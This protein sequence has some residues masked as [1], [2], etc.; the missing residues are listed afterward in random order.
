[1]TR[2]PELDI[3]TV[4][5]DGK[6]DLPAANWTLHTKYYTA[7]I[8]FVFVDTHGNKS[9]D[10]DA[11]NAESVCADLMTDCQALMMVHDATTADSL[12]KL[13]PWQAVLDIFDIPMVFCVGNEKQHGHGSSPQHA[14]G[15]KWSESIAAIPVEY[16]EIPHYDDTT[17]T[18]DAKRVIGGSSL[19]D[20][21]TSSGADSLAESLSCHMWPNMA[22]ND[23]SVSRNVA[24]SSSRPDSSDN[25]GSFQSAAAG[26]GGLSSEMDEKLLADMKAR[27]GQKPQGSDVSAADEAAPSVDTGSADVN[28][29]AGANVDADVDADAAAAAAAAKK[30]EKN[31]RKKQRQKQR[32][33]ERQQAERSAQEQASTRTGIQ[34]LEQ[35]LAAIRANSSDTNPFL[36]G[37]PTST[38]AASTNDD[39]EQEMETFAAMFD[40]IRAAREQA[41]N[42]S[43]DERRRI[44]EK[45]IMKLLATYG[46]MD[47]ESDPDPDPD[48]VAQDSES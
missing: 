30:R 47:D 13:V 28:V 16:V 40:S 11:S 29:D 41:P 35:K 23:P 3:V 48:T 6:H 45:N 2:T 22:R 24:T 20:D 39:L 26:L 43:D 32:K 8:Q 5:I 19:L 27:Y 1:L 33:K 18:A 21:T 38:E 7:D 42:M 15:Y 4:S 44:A 46:D 12:E 9:L 34:A 31:R 25:F 17:I 10:F 14:A 37:V 36:N